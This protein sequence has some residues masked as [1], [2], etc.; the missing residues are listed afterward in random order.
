VTDTGRLAGLLRQRARLVAQASR[1][2]PDLHAVGAPDRIVTVIAN[3]RAAALAAGLSADDV[4]RRYHQLIGEYIAWEAG[5][6]GR[7]GSEPA[8]SL[9]QIRAE[10]DVLDRQIV[11]CLAPSHPM[12]APVTRSDD[13]VADALVSRVLAIL[14][15]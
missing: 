11:A 12:D 8:A 6:F 1:L 14:C 13:P 5:C 2:K 15:G 4:E 7:A 3:V 10:I 9:D